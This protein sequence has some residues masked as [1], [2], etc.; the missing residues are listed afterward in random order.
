LKRIIFKRLYPS[1]EIYQIR[2]EK[3]GTF[4]YDE[5][6]K[7]QTAGNKRKIDYV[8][9][10]EENVKMLS[11]YLAKNLSGIKFGLCHGTRRGKEQEWFRKYLNAEVIGT[12]I[13]D[14]ATTFPNTIQWDFHDVKNEWIGNVDFIYSN[15]L[16]HSYDARYCLKQWFSCLRKNGICIINGTTSNSPWS[17]D[18]LDPFGY[19]KN[20]LKSLINELSGECGVKIEEILRGN[21]KKGFSEWFYF[22]IRKLE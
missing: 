18:R 14:T 4:A 17:T 12:E 9:E 8:F 19:T 21:A 13:S 1:R 22:I 7:I 11:S 3:D 6:K 5:Y 16:D 20:G 10:S 2:F 15:S